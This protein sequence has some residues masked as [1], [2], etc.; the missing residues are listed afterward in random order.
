MISKISVPLDGSKLSEQILPFVQSLAAPHNLPVDLFTV[1][2]TETRSPFRPPQAGKRYLQDIRETYFPTPARAAFHVEI[3]E[4]AEVIVER[5]RTDPQCL[6]AMA[7]HG[8]SGVRRWLL[9]SVASKVVQRAV[10]P[11][12]LIRPVEGA[13]PAMPVKFTTIIVPL[14]GSALAEKILPHVV[15]LA[16]NLKLE[17]QLLRMFE[18]PPNAYVVADGVIAQGPTPYREAMQKEAELY[19]AGKV[20]QLRAEGLDRVI[21]TAIEGDAAGEIVDIA[22]RTDHNLIAMCSH[23]RSGIGRWLLGSV[24]EKVVQHSRDPVLVIRPT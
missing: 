16:K 3:G 21:A 14:D 11:L 19:L 4:P 10:N 24:A 22:R 17:V 5:N 1:T 23:G 8:T 6:I 12:L 18:P 2:D 13:D 20:D 15:T 9:G 7:T